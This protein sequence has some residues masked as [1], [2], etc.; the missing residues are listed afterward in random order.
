MLNI[1]CP[2]P[3]VELLSNSKILKNNNSLQNYYATF[4]GAFPQRYLL[5]SDRIALVIGYVIRRS[6]PKLSDG[7]LIIDIK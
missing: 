6:P 1:Q 7:P 4:V 2:P 3:K 5:D